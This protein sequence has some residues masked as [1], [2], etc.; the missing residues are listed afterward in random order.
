M[1][2]LAA[3][4]GKTADGAE[5]NCRRGV[6]TE[7]GTAE[8]GEAKPFDD[9]PGYGGGSDG[10]SLAE[11]TPENAAVLGGGE[12]KGLKSGCPDR[13]LE[14]GSMEMEEMCA[15]ET[16]VGMGLGKGG[17]GDFQSE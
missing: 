14:I 17:I 6:V 2:T 3:E 13:I 1:T 12:R 16:A 5:P 4:A 9:F 11:D 10:G 15:M 8:F 7:T